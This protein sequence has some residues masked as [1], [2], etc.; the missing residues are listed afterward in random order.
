MT[1]IYE[2]VV[3]IR[4][5]HCD[6]AGIVYHPQYFAILN[7]VMED[8]FR[9]VL[10]ITFNDVETVGVGLPVAGVR[11]DFAAPGRVG[12]VCTARLWAEHIGEKSIRFAITRHCGEELRLQCV[13]TV[14]CV[15]LENG[16]LVS[17]PIPDELRAKL[18][19]YAADETTPPLRLRA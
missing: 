9:D 13:E 11:C 14:V 19:P 2:S 16:R 5:G 10:G 18:A 4:F 6:P 17:T 3:R 8:F 15:K 7:Y 12:D 1:Q